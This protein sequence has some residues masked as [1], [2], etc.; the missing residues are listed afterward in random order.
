MTL[1][2]LRKTCQLH[3]ECPHDIR[4]WEDD[5]RGPVSFLPSTGRDSCY[6]VDLGLA[7][8]MLLKCLCQA[9]LCTPHFIFMCYGGKMHLYCSL[10]DILLLL[11]GG[12]QYIN[13][14]E[15]FHAGYLCIPQHSFIQS[16]IYIS[17]KHR[18]LF[19]ALSYNPMVYYLFCCSNCS[20]FIWNLL[21]FLMELF[22]YKE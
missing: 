20:N 6:Q 9:V 17:M 7:K 3:E 13:Y 10:G 16:F 8:G 21:F 14:L 22:F 5:Q 11:G 15:S 12:L 1:M 18:F 4:F 2:L 19:Y